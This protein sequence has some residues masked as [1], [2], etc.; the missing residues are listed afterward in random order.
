MNSIQLNR[1]SMYIA[2][3][4][5][6]LNSTTAIAALVALA[7]K[8]AQLKTLISRVRALS[9]VQ[10]EPVTG[11][12]VVRDEALDD[13][14]NLSLEVASAVRSYAHTANLAELATQVRV[15]RRTFR[16]LRNVQRMELAQRIH[17]AARTVVAELE[18][19]GVTVE[20]L[21]ELQ[22]TINDTDDAV[23]A[24]RNTVVA[25][26]VATTQL[27]E[28]YQEI[29]ALLKNEIDPLLFANRRKYPDLWQGYQAARQ[30]LDLPGARSSDESA[31]AAAETTTGNTA[32]AAA[33]STA[34]Q[35]H[36][37]TTRFTCPGNAALTRAAF[38]CVM[39]GAWARRRSAEEVTTKYPPSP[40]AM[41]D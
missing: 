1:L 15:T 33:S 24:P 14:M 40:K 11:K 10:A 8:L 39:G 20:T 5:L 37:N 28:A 27:A 32:A 36:L 6:F 9:R 31:A 2:V 3:Q 21:A 7:P 29:E 16:N 4:V 35:G 13:A 25:K 23:S 30:V 18:P 26:K 22:A 41:A 19:F 34:T 17:D 38:F 12:R